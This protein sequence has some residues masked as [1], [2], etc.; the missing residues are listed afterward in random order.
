DA[1]AVGGRR[2]AGEEPIVGAPQRPDH[3]VPHDAL[4]DDL[5]VGVAHHRVV[6][7]VEVALHH[8]RL[9]HVAERDGPG[10]LGR[11]AVLGVRI[12]ARV[13]IVGVAARRLGNRLASAGIGAL[14]DPV[15]HRPDVT[16]GGSGQQER[17]HDEWSQ[18]ERFPWI[19]V[20]D[21][22]GGRRTGRPARLH[23][24]AP[25]VPALGARHPDARR[26]LSRRILA[27]F[28]GLYVYPP[29]EGWVL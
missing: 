23:H 22:P 20:V 12:V 1:D 4:D 11:V 17:K 3:A 2:L 24:T 18:H 13:A 15:L 5:L 27:E 26:R 29:G 8:V 16:P 10:L 14:L 25:R 7:A 19:R 6:R 9:G 28:E 21:C